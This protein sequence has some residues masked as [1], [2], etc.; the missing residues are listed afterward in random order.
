MSPPII[1]T[2]MQRSLGRGLDDYDGS[3]ITVS[4]DRW[5]LVMVCDTISSFRV[6]GVLLSGQKPHSLF[7]EG[8]FEKIVI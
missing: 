1:W 5:F 6:M 2:Q 4:H 3:I 8:A 7:G